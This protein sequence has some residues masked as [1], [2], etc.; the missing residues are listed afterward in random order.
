MKN[1]I[2]A[3]TYNLLL[4]GVM[5]IAMLVWPAAA[6]SEHGLFGHG[7]ISDGDINRGAGT[8]SNNC[9]RC[10]EL[11]SPTEFRDDIWKPIVTHMRVRAGLT[12]QQSRDV[13]A[14]LQ[15]S[16]HPRAVKVS[17]NDSS[18]GTGL[19]GKDIYSQTCVACHGANGS[20][21]IPGTPDFTN[22]GGALS[23]SDDEL[24]RNITAGF[25]SPGSPMAMPAKGGNPDL[26][27]VDV[28]AVLDYLRASF[29]Q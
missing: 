7:V 27:A 1:A 24:I 4:S 18:P 23:K 26:N 14:F 9:A 8:W 6:Y 2:S 15:A 11:R 10:H 21:A 28:R 25:Q 19:S 20:G 22:P 29:G 13:L 17:V 12:G 16:N 5:A 3:T